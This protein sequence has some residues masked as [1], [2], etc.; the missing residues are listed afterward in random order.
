MCLS[1]LS[2]KCRDCLLV[3]SCEHKRKEMLGFPPIPDIDIQ[4]GVDLKKGAEFCL[5]HTLRVADVFN[6]VGDPYPTSK[7]ELERAIRLTIQE[8]RYGTLG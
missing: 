3:E 4:D 1:Q 6:S 8:A 7:D 5:E 2:E